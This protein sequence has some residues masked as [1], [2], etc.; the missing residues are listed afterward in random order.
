MILMLEVH[1]LEE[2]KIFFV[3]FNSLETLKESVINKTNSKGIE[4]VVQSV[5]NEFAH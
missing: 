2:Y 5:V 4:I 3:Y 1:G